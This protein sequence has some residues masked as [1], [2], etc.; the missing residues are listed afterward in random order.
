MLMAE[1]VQ[2]AS[3]I[4]DI[5]VLLQHRFQGTIITVFVGYKYTALKTD[6]NT[7]THTKISFKKV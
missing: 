1:S 6:I 5:K 3:R 7:H 2:A 4:L